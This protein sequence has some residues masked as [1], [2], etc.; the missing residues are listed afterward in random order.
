MVCGPRGLTGTRVA[1]R[2]GAVF[3]GAPGTARAHF[4][5]A[6][7]AQTLRISHVTVT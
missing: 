3:S 6:R 1:A 5:V 2:A 7:S 4:M